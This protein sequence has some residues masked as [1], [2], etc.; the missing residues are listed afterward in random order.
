[1]DWFRSVPAPSAIP[2]EEEMRRSV[3]PTCAALALLL[4]AAGCERVE[5]AP[6]GTFAEAKIQ[7]AERGVPVLLDFFTEW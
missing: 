1:L 7:A 2:H 4:V 6:P 5:Q 3:L